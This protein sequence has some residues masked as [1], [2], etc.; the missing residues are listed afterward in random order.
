MK[1]SGLMYKK[2]KCGSYF[3]MRHEAKLLSHLCHQNPLTP[4]IFCSMG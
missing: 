2:T 3:R 4:P 1:T